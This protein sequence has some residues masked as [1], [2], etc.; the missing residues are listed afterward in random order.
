MRASETRNA[1]RRDGTPTADAPRSTREVRRYYYFI[2]LWTQ[3]TNRFRAFEG[4]GAHA[5]HRAL[6]DTETGEFTTATVNRL[7]QRQSANLGPIV[8]LDAGCGYGGACLDLAKAMDGH[9]HGIT[10][11]EPQVK[12]AQRNA[13]AMGLGQ[14]VTFA[15]ASFDEPVP[16]PPRGAYNLVFGV[17][18]LIH[19]A[20]PARTIAN[21]VAALAPGGLFIIVDDM[22]AEPPLPAY[23]DDLAGFKRMWRCPVMPTAAAWSAHLVA[24]GCRL[25]ASEDLT[26][27]MGPRGDAEILAAM[28]DLER[29]RR[30]RDRLGLAMV[31]DAQGGGLLLERLIN[32]RAVRYQMLVARKAA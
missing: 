29:R 2:Y 17:E 10:I 25:E 20:D 3:L 26:D 19:S 23:A 16:R 1:D 11:A 21:L 32:A 18:S 27:R 14:R 28:A 22:P 6:I 9:W 4:V 8:A 15:L 12:I 5:I 7:I 31:S 24:A 30:W 13:D